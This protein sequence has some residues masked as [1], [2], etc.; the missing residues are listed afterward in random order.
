MEL[1]SKEKTI[2][3]LKVLEPFNLDI[4]NWAIDVIKGMHPV[5]CDGC[6]WWKNYY[7]GWNGQIR[8]AD[9]VCENWREQ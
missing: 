9:S 2:E 7:C 5:R 1:I 8:G 3:L 4:P 6:K